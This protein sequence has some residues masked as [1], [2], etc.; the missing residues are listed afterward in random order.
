MNNDR[1][2]RRNAA[3]AYSMTKHSLQMRTHIAEAER[4]RV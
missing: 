3:L 2:E 4:R 1:R